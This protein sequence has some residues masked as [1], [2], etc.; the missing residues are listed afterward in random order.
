MKDDF[1][2]ELGRAL[3]RIDAAYAELLRLGGRTCDGF[4]E[5]DG[6]LKYGLGV[7]EGYDI[8]LSL[9]GE[10]SRI[11]AATNCHYPSLYVMKDVL[12]NLKNAAKNLEIEVKNL[13][14]VARVGEAA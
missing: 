1:R 13:K 10:G 6:C 5:E 9:N 4:Y 12:P 8:F 7:H 11:Y 3:E 2:L 14:E